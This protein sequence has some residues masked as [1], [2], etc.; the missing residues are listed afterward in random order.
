M[1][2][3]AILILMLTS[4]LSQAQYFYRI[5]YISGKDTIKANVVAMSKTG[6][7]TMANAAKPLNYKAVVTYIRRA[8]KTEKL[9]AI[10]W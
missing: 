3:I 7:T 2:I 1:R 5:N 9:N 6:A 8:R 10:T 4:S